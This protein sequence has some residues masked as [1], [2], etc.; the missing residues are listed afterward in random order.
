M[1]VRRARVQNVKCFAD[2]E[3]RFQARAVTGDPQSNWNVILGENGDGKTSLLQ[4]IAAC[5]MDATTAG[6]MLKPVSWVRR[7]AKLAMLE[8]TLVKQP[9]D[10]QDGK[11]PRTELAERT[12][13]YRVLAPG[14]GPTQNGKHAFLP[15]AEII[16]ARPEY[17]ELFGEDYERLFRDIDYLRRNAFARRNKRGWFSAG[18]GPFR[19]LS[20]FSSATAEVDDPLE[21]RFL[22]LFE[23]GAALFDCESWLKELDRRAARSHKGSPQRALLDESKE[24]LTKLLPEIDEIEIGDEVQFR[25]RGSDTGLAQLSDGYRSMFALAV[26]ILRWL[27]AARWEPGVA[28]NEVHG[29]VLIDEIDAHLHPKW[30]RQ[31]GFLLCET[32]PNLQFIVTSHSPFVAMA[33]GAGALTLLTREGDVVRENQDLP[34]VR[35]WAVDQVLSQLFGLVSLRDP[36]TEG[37]LDRYE[38]LRTRR[39]RGGLSDG[40]ARELQD[41]ERYLNERMTGEPEAPKHREIDEDL[42]LLAEAR[43]AKRGTGDA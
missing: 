37:K 31:A 23:E 43:R 25:W 35:G 22:T 21:K 8:A 38:D 1:Y 17:S 18:Y 15:T 16:D 6:R 30:Q 10:K 12:V 28:L 3:L 36:E 27:E 32:F 42:A 7:G 29:V 14:E 40:E 2:V 19:R 26:D 9:G 20:G 11:P 39:R 13:S 24:L 4:A 5:L 41:L 34:Y 33:A